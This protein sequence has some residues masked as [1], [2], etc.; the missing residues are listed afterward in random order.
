MRRIP[1]TV[2]FLLPLRYGRADPT[3]SRLF[4]KLAVERNHLGWYGTLPIAVSVRI[5]RGYGTPPLAGVGA[6]IVKL[7]RGILWEKPRLVAFAVRVVRTPGASLDS[8]EV[9]ITREDHQ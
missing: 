9:T 2:T 6:Y 7:F 4:A 8:V 5:F 3:K 1:K